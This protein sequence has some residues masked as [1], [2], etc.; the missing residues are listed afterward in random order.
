M[1]SDPNIRFLAEKISEYHN[2]LPELEWQL[3]ERKVLIQLLGEK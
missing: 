1:P 3:A 2:T